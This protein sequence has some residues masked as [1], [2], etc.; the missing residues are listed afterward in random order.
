MTCEEVNE[1]L[2]HYLNGTLPWRQ[3]LS[4]NVHLLVRQHC[5]QYMASYAATVRTTKSQGLPAGPRADRIP[6]EL[7][8][9]IIS[10]RRPRS[11]TKADGKS[12]DASA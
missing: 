7:V 4:F 5:R 11:V 1:F 12:G 2:V 9:A 10:V 8:R 3:R 6:D